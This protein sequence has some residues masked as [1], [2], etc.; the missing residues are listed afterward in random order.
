[1][2]FEVEER[3]GGVAGWVKGGE[4]FDFEFHGGL[5]EFLGEVETEEGRG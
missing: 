2:A 5:D 3:G 1:M 4:G